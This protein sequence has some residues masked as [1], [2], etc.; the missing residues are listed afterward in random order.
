MQLEAISSFSTTY[1]LRKETDPL[2]ATTS[3]Q[4]VESDKV[5]TEPP[6]LQAK[7]PQLPQLLFLCFVH[8]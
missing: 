8:I 1:Y 6:F 7:K 3:F 2:M 5:I 4:V